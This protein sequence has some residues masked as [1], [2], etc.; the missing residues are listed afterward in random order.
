MTEETR[1]TWSSAARLTLTVLGLGLLASLAAGL[2]YGL[3][4]GDV[5][6]GLG[7][8]VAIGMSVTAVIGVALNFLW[9]TQPPRQGTRST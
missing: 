2:V 9:P 6:R 8:T 4:I 5:A 7:Q 3:I 1:R